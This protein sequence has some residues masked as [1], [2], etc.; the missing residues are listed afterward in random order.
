MKVVICSKNPVKILAVKE[1]FRMIFN[2]VDYKALDVNGAPSVLKQPMSLEETL[3][4]ALARIK[5]AKHIEKAD[6]YVS[7][8]GG[9]GR[10]EY[11]AFLT[12]YVCIEDTKGK[13]GIGGGYRM[14]LPNSIYS[15]LCNDKSLEL[16]DVID[17]LLDD[18]NT[19]QKGG[20]VF[21]FTNG[22]IK[23]KDVFREAVIFALVP[24]TCKFFDS[25]ET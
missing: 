22:L 11:G 14:P 12:G 19:K 21:A 4:S 16:G 15:R 10:D 6:Y 24:F 25:A 7:L 17:E 2:N 20:A 5:A 3:K 13:R 8:E 18:H 9:V 23:R 1:A